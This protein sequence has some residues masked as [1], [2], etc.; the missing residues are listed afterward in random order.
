MWERSGESAVTGG[1]SA[2][3]HHDI[4]SPAAQN[5]VSIR[6][7]R[8]PVCVRSVVLSTLAA[9]APFT[10]FSTPPNSLSHPSSPALPF[11]DS[12]RTSTTG[13]DHLTLI[14]HTP[15]TSTQLQ[16]HRQN[17]HLQG[18]LLPRRAAPACAITP[19]SLSDFTMLCAYG[20]NPFTMS[21]ALTFS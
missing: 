10:Q 13:P 12:T 7:P 3:R 15:S 16:S 4:V 14:L 1:W 5:P 8:R 19:P 21:T 20:H 18:M 2:I 17:D 6:H 11:R 9:S